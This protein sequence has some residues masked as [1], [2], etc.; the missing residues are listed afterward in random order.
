[1]ITLCKKAGR[2]L[3]ALSRISN[4]MSFEKKTILL[5]A[6]VE[7]QFGY[8]PLTW[9]FHGRKANAKINHIHERALR[10]VYKDNNSS[11]EELL[12]KDKSFCIHHRNI[13]SLTFELF[14]V[15]NNLSNKI[16]CDIFETRNFNYNLKA[17][18]QIS[19]IRC[20]AKYCSCD[21]AC[22]FPAL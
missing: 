3:S 15:K 12:R 20:S 9:V 5:K 7:S 10:I 4:Y 1:M 22:Q 2:K 14:K 18:R 16:M 8:C 13:Q 19:K 21:K 11:F 17:H 6:F